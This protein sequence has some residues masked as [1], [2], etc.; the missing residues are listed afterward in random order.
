MNISIEKMIRSD[1]G[2]THMELSCGKVSAYVGV[3]KG[4][5]LQVCTMN[6][7]HKVWRG[8]GKYFRT[9]SEA[10]ENYRSA[11]MKAIIAAAVDAAQIQQPAALNA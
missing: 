4:G 5:A 6:A 11:E 3:E 10:L 9:T 7:S 2:T 1:Y 8:C